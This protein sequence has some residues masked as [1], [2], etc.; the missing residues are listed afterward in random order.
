M[1]HWTPAGNNLVRYKEL[2]FDSGLI[3]IQQIKRLLWTEC[4]INIVTPKHAMQCNETSVW[5]DLNIKPPAHRIPGIYDSS[6]SS[7]SVEL[8]TVGWFPECT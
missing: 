2:Y 3:G 8:T 6:L 1:S 7:L 4:V 5:P